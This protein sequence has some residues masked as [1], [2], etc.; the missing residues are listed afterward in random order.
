MRIFVTNRTTDK[1]PHRLTGILKTLLTSPQPTYF[2]NYISTVRPA[3]CSGLAAAEKNNFMGDPLKETP[4]ENHLSDS[5][6]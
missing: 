3:F 2:S 1:L 6:L 4:S 5:A